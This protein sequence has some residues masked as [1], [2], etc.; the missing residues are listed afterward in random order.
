MQRPDPA[1]GW[2]ACWRA[3]H[4]CRC[5]SRWRTVSGAAPL[6]RARRERR[7]SSGPRWPT[8]AFTR[9]RPRRS[10]S[11]AVAGTSKRTRPRR[12]LAQLSCDGI[13]GTSLQQAARKHAAL[14]W[15]VWHLSRTDG[16]RY[17]TLRTPSGACGMT[18]AATEAG[19]MPAP[20]SARNRSGNPHAQG[21]PIHVA[22]RADLPEAR[23]QCRK[24]AQIA[25]DPAGQGHAVDGDQGPASRPPACVLRCGGPV[26]LDGKGAL[27]SAAS[28][29]TGMVVSIPQ[30][31]GL[32]WPVP[33]FPTLNRRQKP[34]AVQ[35]SG[36][37]A[38]GLLN[39]P[40]DAKPSRHHESAPD[41]EGDQVLRRSRMTG[42]QQHA[43]HA[44]QARQSHH[45]EAM[46]RPSCPKPDRS[47]YAPRR[48][49]RTGGVL[50]PDLTS[51]GVRIA[52]RGP[53][54]QTA[55][56]HLVNRLNALVTAESKRIA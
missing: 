4:Q 3:S 34:P 31:A 39:L 18:M 23:Q 35:I 47:V 43:L 12:H 20:D 8:V 37:C 6:V 42:P 32:D 19:D 28:A 7:A 10:K 16:V 21:A 50:R 40:I 54:R 48:F 2:A 30:M 38:P 44:S 27:R 33:D 45:L 14:I 25:A 41:G 15:E 22:E 49:T 26:L 1:P 11:S 29:T 51:F 9:L 56:T 13:R 17:L 55:D 52:L 36:H 5:G 24:A 53:D 46:A